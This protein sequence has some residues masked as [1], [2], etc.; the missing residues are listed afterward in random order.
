MGHGMSCMW[1]YCNALGMNCFRICMWLLMFVHGAAL[2]VAA[3]QFGCMLWVHEAKIVCL[4]V[5]WV[6]FVQ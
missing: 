1:V 5:N 3:M 6:E 4:C 2:S